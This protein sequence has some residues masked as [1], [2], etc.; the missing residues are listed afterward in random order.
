MLSPHETYLVLAIANIQEPIPKG[1][2]A[3][4]ASLIHS[5]KQNIEPETAATPIVS[6]IIEDYHCIV[7]AYLG[8]LSKPKL[9]IGAL[10]YA[11]KM[12]S[13]LNSKKKIAIL[14]AGGVLRSKKLQKGSTLSMLANAPVIN[15]EINDYAGIHVF[16]LF[17]KEHQKENPLLA[18]QSKRISPFIECRNAEPKP[19]QGVRSTGGANTVKPAGGVKPPLLKLN[20]N[21]KP[22]EQVTYS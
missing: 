13:L 18:Y 15:K 1:N 10:S 22:F 16:E 21:L 19:E 5:I 9:R 12:Q 3:A 14:S 4:L 11:L 17:W 20:L 2:L 6:N 8:K 7:Y